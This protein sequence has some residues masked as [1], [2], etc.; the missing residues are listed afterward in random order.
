MS[1][2]LFLSGAV[3]SVAIVYGLGFLFATAAVLFLGY[4]LIGR[5][6]H[7]AWLRRRLRYELS[8]G[9]LRVWKDGRDVPECTIGLTE[10]IHVEPQFVTQSGRGTIELPPGGWS[11]QPGWMNR[12]DRDLPALYP[13]RRLELI[14][15]VEAVAATIRRAAR[16]ALE[17]GSGLSDARLS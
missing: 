10:L 6:Y 4:L 16:A 1:G 17:D 9:G 12:W 2:A 15:D 3:L 14:E 13:C 8:N 11:A 7:D 5:F